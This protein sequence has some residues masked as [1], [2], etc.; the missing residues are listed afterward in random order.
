MSYE[1]LYILRYVVR[2]VHTR[3]D[4]ARFAEEE[5]SLWEV[6]RLGYLAW[7]IR[8]GEASCGGELS[9]VILRFFWWPS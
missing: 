8:L 7:A 5:S 6:L 2:A 1:E 9:K 4:A 3:R